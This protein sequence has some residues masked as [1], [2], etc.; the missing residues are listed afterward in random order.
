[1]REFSA[2]YYR[3]ILLRAL[4]DAGFTESEAAAQAARLTALFEALE[5]EDPAEIFLGPAARVRQRELLNRLCKPGAE[6]PAAWI[7]A[8]LDRLSAGLAAHYRRQAL[9]SVTGGVPA[10]ALRRYP[11]P[12]AENLPPPPET[13]T[14]EGVRA[15]LAAQEADPAYIAADARRRGL[16]DPEAPFTPETALRQIRYVVEVFHV[17]IPHAEE[18]AARLATPDLPQRIRTGGRGVVREVAARLITAP[19]RNGEKAAYRYCACWAPEYY[20][21][22]S[23]SVAAALRALRDRLGFYPFLDRELKDADKFRRI[24]LIF[25]SDYALQEFN[26]YQCC[27]YLALVGA[28][29]AREQEE[30]NSNEKKDPNV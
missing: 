27:R 19:G 30:I 18:T 9:E 5:K 6:P 2:S 15:V 7:S 1:M 12:D 4:D 22:C 20:P 23:P 11:G 26:A 3:E 29:L 13:P 10:D 25:R 28:R 8:G 17:S 16:F 21:L 24:L 14:P